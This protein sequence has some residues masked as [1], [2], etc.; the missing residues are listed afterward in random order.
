MG[1][2]AAL[3]V[4]IGLLL[5]YLVLS[6]VCTTINE[7]I[8]TVLRLRA[9]SLTS[10]LKALIDDPGVKERFFNH[11]LIVNAEVSSRGG[12]APPVKKK[13]DPTTKSVAEQP[14]EGDYSSYLN[15]KNFA[16]ALLDSVV[17]SNGS[18]GFPPMDQ[19]K[20]SINKLPDSNIR[21]VLLA[22]LATAEDDFAKL[23]ESVKNWFD[24]AM[25]RLSGQY[26]RLA[27]KISLVIGLI[28]ALGLGADS[29]GV[30]ERLWNDAALRAD[31]AQQAIAFV[32]NPPAPV[33]DK[34][35]KE[36]PEE[37]LA[38]L[39]S[40]FDTQIDALRAFP[41]GWN[42]NTPKDG[43]GWLLAILG[44]LWTGIALSLGSPFWFDLLQRFVRVRG[45]GAKPSG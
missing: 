6:L 28:V 19:I 23:Q 43:A 25:D 12:V 15:G 13:A 26:T 38:C 27:K 22:C 40:E 1:F 33:A 2:S 4:C 41:I 8:A 39:R 34:C 36:K 44:C 20:E 37:Q 24:T 42:E 21:D 14:A 7:I 11:G 10:A 45:T 16:L 32:N 9:K 3:D 29:F 31:L 17:K 18:A 30:G 35:K 5:M